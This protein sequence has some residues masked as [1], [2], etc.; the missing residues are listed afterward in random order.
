MKLRLDDVVDGELKEY[1]LSQEGI[2]DVIFTN[3]DLIADIYIKFDNSINP[4]IIMKY[5]ELFQ[6]YNYSAILEFDKGYDGKFKLLK[7]IVDDM[8][9]EYCYKGLVMDLFE[10]DKIKSVKSNFDFNKPPFDIEFLIEY[11]DNCDEQ[12]LKKYIKLKYDY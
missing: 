10:N 8:C 2:N 6:G 5:I 12:E 11:D 7:Y 3:K 9:C 1:L 4:M